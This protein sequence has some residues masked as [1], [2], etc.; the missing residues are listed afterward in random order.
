ML[1]NQLDYFSSKVSVHLVWLAETMISIWLNSLWI[2]S[3]YRSNAAVYVPRK[4]FCNFLLSRLCVQL[5]QLFYIE[6]WP[7]FCVKAHWFILYLASE[8]N[9]V[10]SKQFLQRMK[11][12]S[13]SSPNHKIIYIFNIVVIFVHKLIFFLSNAIGQGENKS[14]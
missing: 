3:I 1:Q 4:S 8:T 11:K 6:S 14:Y 12:W 5:E 7:K 9:Q 2:F 10:A 13:I